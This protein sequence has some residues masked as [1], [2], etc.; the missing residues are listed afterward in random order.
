MSASRPVYEFSLS[1]S[2]RVLMVIISDNVLEN[3]QVSIDVLLK[4]LIITVNLELYT[5]R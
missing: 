1:F 3:S 4:Y 2:K 5:K